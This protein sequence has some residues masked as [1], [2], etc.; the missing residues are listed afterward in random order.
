M[1]TLPTAKLKCITVLSAIKTNTGT[2][3][4]NVKARCAKKKMPGTNIQTITARRAIDLS[5]EDVRRF[6]RSLRQVF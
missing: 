5:V 2:I 6:L 1:F 3:L 4:Q